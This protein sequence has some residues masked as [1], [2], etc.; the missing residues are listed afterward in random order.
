MKLR[1][2]EVFHAVYASGS[3]SAAARQLNVSQPAVTNLLQHAEDLLGFPLFDRLRGRLVPTGDAHALFEQA[4]EIQT[5][6]Y[7]FRETARN[8]RRGRGSPLRISTLPSLGMKLLPEAV[9]SFASDHEGTT[10]ELHTVHHDDMATK[11]Y[12][13][14]ADL[15]I[16][17][18]PPR[19]MPVIVTRIGEGQMYA[20]CRESDLPEAA[21]TTFPLTALHERRYISINDSGPQGRTLANEM[22][23]RDIEPEVVGVSR[24]YSIAAAMAEAGLGTTIV[25]EHT[26]Q[27][28]RHEG[29]ALR[30]LD[31]PLAYPINAVFLEASPPS[32][33]A[34]DFLDHLK[35][36]LTQP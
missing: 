23:A 21:G 10:I 22:A 34:L 28:M 9:T 12:E 18:S 27:A 19:D 26:A 5:K 17:Y 32:R 6:V 8:L 13:R 20:C 3:V 33:L 29:M 14:E 31:P 24:T 25:D 11:L 7:Q 36:R 16:C 2:I 35:G 15:V 1:H 30:P 4:E